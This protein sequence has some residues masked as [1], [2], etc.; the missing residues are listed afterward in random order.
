MY[1]YFLVLLEAFLVIVRRSTGPDFDKK[2]K[3]PK[4]SKNIAIGPGTL[5]RHF[6]KSETPQKYNKKHNETK[7]KQKNE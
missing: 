7:T 2:P 6:G 4:S 1:P 3:F 5:T